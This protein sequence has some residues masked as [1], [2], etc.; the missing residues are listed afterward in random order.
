MQRIWISL[1]LLGLCVSI[2]AQDGSSSNPDVA[3][4]QTLEAIKKVEPKFPSAAQGKILSGEV[5]VSVEIAESGDVSG[6][7]LVG[8]NSMLSD[9]AIGAAKQWKFKPF[10]RDGKPA[11][12]KILLPFKLVQPQS[13][14]MSVK[15]ISQ[16]DQTTKSPL[17]NVTAEVIPGSP[18]PVRVSQNIMQSFVAQRVNPVYPSAAR[19]AKIQGPVSLKVLVGKDGRVRHVEAVSGPAQLVDAA[20]YAVQQWRYRI[21][22][23]DDQAVE[24]ETMVTINYTIAG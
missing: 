3:P 10:T 21:F 17:P 11:K 19:Q 7:E 2:W 6:V 12:I 23:L 14:P 15:L 16:P 24:V 1:L 8:G 9:A 13:S 4:D 18:K 22:V 20:M 5:V